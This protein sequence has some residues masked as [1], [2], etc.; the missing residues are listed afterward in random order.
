MIHHSASISGTNE[1]VMTAT[2]VRENG[3]AQFIIGTFEDGY[4]HGYWSV[5]ELLTFASQLSNMAVALNERLE[6][7]QHPSLGAVSTVPPAVGMNL[8]V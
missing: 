2:E 5:S 1:I 7:L 3:Q 4:I 6:Y 8:E